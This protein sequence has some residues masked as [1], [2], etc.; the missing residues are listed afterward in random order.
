MS[1]TRARVVGLAEHV[2]AAGIGTWSPDGMFTPRQ[3]GI[4]TKDMP[5]SPDR[6]IAISPYSTTN[7]L[8]G[9]TIQ[10]V[11]FRCRGSE[12]KPLD[13]DDLADALYQLLHGAQNLNLGP[14]A[15]KLAWR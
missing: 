14:V 6:V 8:Q 13:S 11:Q 10:P 9:E 5:A 4:T 12:G 7:E 2:A 3:T 15:V 1:D